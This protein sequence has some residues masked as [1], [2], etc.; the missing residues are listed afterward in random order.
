MNQKGSSN[1]IL[2]IGILVVLAGS[3][4]YWFW[5]QKSDTPVTSTANELSTQQ[6]TNTKKQVVTPQPTAPA[7]D[8]TAN[9]KTYT[10][11][12]YGYHIKYPSDWKVSAASVVSNGKDQE[13]WVT[14]QDAAGSVDRKIVILAGVDSDGNLSYLR[15]APVT[16]QA[17]VA[18]ES[19]A[20]Y[21]F[22]KNPGC[23]EGELSDTPC[24]SSFAVPIYRDGIWYELIAN[25][26]ADTYAGTYK[27]IFSTFGFSSQ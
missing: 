25:Y 3:I 27:D 7:A 11:A 20:V 8:N 14:H 16:S 9:W 4:G 12:T 22:P 2:I 19:Q 5:T 24:Y 15:T 1:P 13:V 26:S 21:I 18:G 23:V 6:N 10:N 17:T